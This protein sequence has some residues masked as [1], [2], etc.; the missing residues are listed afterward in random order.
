M[1][2]IYLK[3][4]TLHACSSYDFVAY[5]A[6]MIDAIQCWFTATITENI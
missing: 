5:Q 3:R 6:Q 1:A 2:D 4:Y